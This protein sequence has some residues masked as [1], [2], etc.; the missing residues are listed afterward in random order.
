MLLYVWDMNA[1]RKKRQEYQSWKKSYFH[2]SSDGWKEGKLFYTDEQYAYGMTIMGL[3]TLRFNLTIYD[4]TLMPNHFHILMSGTGA[5]CVRAFDYYKKKISIRLQE[6]GF[7]PLPRN[8]FFKL[9]PIEDEEQMRIEFLYVDRNTLE[10]GLSLPGGYPWGATYLFYSFLGNYLQGKSAS[11]FPKYTALEKVTGSRILIPPDWQFH[12]Q[13][14]LLPQSFVDKSLFRRLF[15]DPK[16]YLTRLVKEYEAFVKLGKRIG[17]EVVFSNEE[18]TDIVQ[19]QVQL[20]F[21]GKSVHSL[22][23]EDKGRLVVALDSKYSLT[24]T[25]IADALFMREYLVKQ[26]LFSKDYGKKKKDAIRGTPHYD[27]SSKN[28]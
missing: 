18:I 7:P 24:P 3:L 16:T 12:P 5:E 20:H 1:I 2:L 23:N 26:F 6:D 27:Y 25:Q 21:P 19:Q 17:E 22:T 15:P 14:G 10:K 8:Y 9:T 11:S 13:L 4:F 28:S